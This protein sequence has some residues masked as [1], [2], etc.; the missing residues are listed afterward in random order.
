VLGWPLGGMLAIEPGRR[1][2]LYLRALILMATT[3]KF[4]AGPDWEH[5]LDPAVLDVLA[6][7]A[8]GAAA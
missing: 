4:L 6:R 1:H 2:P 3:P 8:G 5:G 7:H